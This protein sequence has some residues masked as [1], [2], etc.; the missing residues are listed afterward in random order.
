MENQALV[1]T[2]SNSLTS[3]GSGFGVEGMEGLG[4]EHIALPRWDILQPISRK[5]GTPG[6][7]ISNLT[8]ETREAL[9]I[10]ILRLT[11]TRVLWS[12]ELSARAPECASSDGIT[13]RTYGHCR[14]CKFNFIPA[15][16]Q[17]VK[18]CRQGF[19]YFCC[20]PQTPA[21]ESISLL[22]SYG[23]SVT[24]ARNFH[25]LLAA[26]KPRPTCSYIVKFSTVLK[27]EPTKYYINEPKILR[28]LEP[29]AWA[30]FLELARAIRG[31]QVEEAAPGEPTD[32]MEDVIEAAQQEVVAQEP[33]TNVARQRLA[34]ARAQ[35]APASPPRELDE[36]QEA[37]WASMGATTRG[38]TA[39]AKD[40]VAA[41][42]ARR[43][44]DRV[45]F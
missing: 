28:K 43:A 40:P 44:D 18:H 20:E 6:W 34:Q 39:P 19:T 38:P 26:G 25:T 41:A 24:P 45:P 8:G 7:Y 14:T 37:L 2:Q 11:P 31:I 30:P 22:S 33:T 5:Q 10:I 15:K 16:G 29:A 17:K 27:L 12:D 42:R 1:A 9:E 4:P 3:P 36:E 13:G 35:A 21:F 23:A 32:S